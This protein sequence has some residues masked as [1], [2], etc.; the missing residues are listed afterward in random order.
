M[1]EDI[2]LGEVLTM[3]L[4]ISLNVI[5]YL[6]LNK[7]KHRVTEESNYKEAFH[8]SACLNNH[9]TIDEIYLPTNNHSVV[10]ILLSI[11]QFV[12]Y[13][14]SITPCD[15]NQFNQFINSMRMGVTGPPGNSLFIYQG[16]ANIFYRSLDSKYFRLFRPYV[17]VVII[18]ICSCITQ[19]AIDN[20]QTNG[21]SYVPIK[22]YLKIGSKLIMFGKPLLYPTVSFRVLDS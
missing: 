6:G 14:L 16:L 20:M 13:C 1:M 4:W 22:L 17:S 15:N 9:F 2:L 19:I 12:I 11:T 10:P 8:T 7:E 21:C 5:A 3:M 18:Q